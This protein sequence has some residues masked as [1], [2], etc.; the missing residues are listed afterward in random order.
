MKDSLRTGI[1]FGLTSAV[2]TTLGLMVGLHSGTHSKVVVLAGILTIAVA[3]A[4]SDAL[5][6]HISEEAENVHTAKQIWV[7]TIATFAAK[8]L[9]AMTFVIPVLYFS[10][11]TAIAVSLLW[12]ML[13]LTTLSYI[14]AKKQG[15]LPWKIVGEHLMIAIV[16]ISITHWVGDW[17][18]SLGSHL[19]L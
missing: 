5:G 8:F 15:E 17:I 11:T 18:G 4:F 1:S 12:G 6:I 10:L 2:I 13:I 16:V 14:I 3:D 7:A 19:K 9:F